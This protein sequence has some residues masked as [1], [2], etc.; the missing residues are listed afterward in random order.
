MYNILVL[1]GDGIG[2]EIMASTIDVL[3]LLEKKL[4]KQIFNFEHDLIG[5]CAYEKYGT[6]LDD[7]TLQKAKDADAVLLGAVGGYQWDDL[8]VDKR[9]EKGLL[10]I[11]KEMGL[12]ANLRPVKI[13]WWFVFW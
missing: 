13:D 10:R 7:T 3:R 4:G 1:A 12:Y 8:P 9:P 2:E 5:G 11:R 6:P